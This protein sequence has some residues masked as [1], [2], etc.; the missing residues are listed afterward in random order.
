MFY[1]H[2]NP[3]TVAFLCPHLPA[4]PRR[5]QAASPASHDLDGL[6]N[7]DGGGGEPSGNLRVCQLEAMTHLYIYI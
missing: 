3:S 1:P 4:S 6:K 7:G 5:S 2:L